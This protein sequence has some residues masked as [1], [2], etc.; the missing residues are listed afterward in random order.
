MKALFFLLVGAAL[1][2]YGFYYFQ[3]QQPVEKPAA[4][5]PASAQATAADGEKSPTLSDRVRGDVQSA[6]DAVSAKLAEWKLTPEDIKKDLERSGQVVRTKAA[7]VGESV[8]NAASNARIAA[9]IKAKFALDKELPARAISVD[10]DQGHVILHGTVA[11]PAL[12]A[13]AVGLALDTEG[14]QKVQSLL[15]VEAPAAK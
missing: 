1:G 10:C 14:V 15:V 4:R 5:E 9:S 2:A 13:K 7:A 3:Q 6:A 11:S 12:I 8:A